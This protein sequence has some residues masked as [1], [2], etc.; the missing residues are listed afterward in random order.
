MALKASPRADAGK[1]TSVV[2]SNGGKY[3]CL[4]WHKGDSCLLEFLN[5]HAASVFPVRQIN[6]VDALE[7][8]YQFHICNIVINFQISYRF[9]LHRNYDL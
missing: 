5:Y 1:F 4:I 8:I 9:Q 7:K 3:F 2:R 6:C